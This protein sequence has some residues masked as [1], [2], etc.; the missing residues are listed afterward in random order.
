MP[1]QSSQPTPTRTLHTDYTPPTSSRL[2]STTPQPLDRPSLQASIGIHS[3][4]PESN[5]PPPNPTPESTM[6]RDAHTPKTTVPLPEPI[7]QPVELTMLPSDSSAVQSEPPEL[8][9]Q[10]AIHPPPLHPHASPEPCPEPP[11]STRGRRLRKANV[12]SLNMC[13]CGVTITDFEIEAGTN[14]MRCRVPGCETVWVCPYLSCGSSLHSHTHS[15]IKRVWT[16]NS[17]PKAGPVIAAQLGIVV[18]VERSL[19]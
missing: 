16:M 11:V 10:L 7:G 5:V 1:S 19:L 12:L 13:T 2:A 8:T 14:I 18:V 3:Q 4:S 9:A 6:P 17:C 15:S